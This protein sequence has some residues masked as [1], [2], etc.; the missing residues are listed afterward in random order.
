MSQRLTLA[1]VP[2]H[3]RCIHNML[4]FRVS[5]DFKRLRRGQ[6]SFGLSCGNFVA[7][8][9]IKEGESLVDFGS[10][11]GIDAFLA[12][13]K[14]EPIG[15]AIGL[16]MSE[17]RCPHFLIYIFLFY[18]YINYACCGTRSHLLARTRRRRKTRTLP[19][20]Y[21]KYKNTSKVLFYCQSSNGRGPRYIG[22][23][24]DYIDSQGD[25]KPTAYILPRRYQQLARE[26]QWR[27]R[28]R[29]YGW[30]NKL[31]YRF[32]VFVD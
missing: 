19:A 20:F 14:V 18:Y 5:E 27:R 17:V 22:W 7:A 8:A 12:A 1:T 23:F 9:N 32:I 2:E 26:V 16:D 25:N 29:W 10:G 21:E 6:L 31:N 30:H 24:Q 3:G 11:G 15:S 28:T 13:G 4:P